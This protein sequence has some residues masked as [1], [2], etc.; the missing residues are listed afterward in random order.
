MFWRCKSILLCKTAI[1]LNCPE[2][3]FRFCIYAAVTFFS[4]FGERKK[5]IR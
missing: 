2:Q 5:V 3:T 4:S 1:L